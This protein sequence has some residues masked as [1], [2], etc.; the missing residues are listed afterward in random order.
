MVV[1]HNWRSTW[2]RP[3]RSVGIGCEDMIVPGIED[4]RNCAGPRNLGQSEWD[5]QLGTIECVFSLYRKMR[6]KLDDMYLFR[7]LPNIY[8]PSC[9]PPSLPVP[10]S[11]YT[12]HRSWK[13]CLEA[14]IKRVWRWTWRLR[15]S[16]LRE[17]LGGRDQARLEMHL[18][19]EI[20]W[21][22]RCT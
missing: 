8:T 6:W 7:G 22:Q 12:H 19:V 21:T 17:A 16:E 14:V 3:L 5:Q 18:E 1:E 15:S 10:I 2:T 13:M 9:C 4:P 11:L 20:E